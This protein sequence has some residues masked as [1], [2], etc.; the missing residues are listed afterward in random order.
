MS[1]PTERLLHA[2][3]DLCDES[4]QDARSRD[5]QLAGARLTRLL[6]E[7]ASSTQ[8]DA[9]LL[10]ASLMQCA[11]QG[12]IALEHSK[13][14]VP[15]YLRLQRIRLAAGAESRLRE[16]L[17]RPARGSTEHDRAWAAALGEYLPNLPAEMA[18][19]LR[20]KPLE[21]AE[22][23]PQQLAQRLA[24]A[25]THLHKGM[26]LREA[27]A[28]AF[29]GNSKVLDGRSAL[30]TAICTK[31]AALPVA[32][33]V[34]IPATWEG[35][36][37]IE[38]EASFIRACQ[39]AGASHS[40]AALLFCSGF[41]GAATR[42]RSVGGARLFV[43]SSTQIQDLHGFDRWLNTPQ[44]NA[45]PVWFFG[46]LDFSGMAILRELR[47]SFIQIKAWQPGYSVLL[48]RLFAGEAH[49]GAESNK[50]GQRD[51]ISTGCEYS[52][53]VLLPAL[54]RTQQFVDQEAFLWN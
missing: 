45:M 10:H 49:F 20:R 27:S 12:L 26:S 3:L 53:T 29:W 35:V 48:E 6:P 30:I 50:Q 54:R 23:S 16:Q 28:R 41:R 39:H 33:Q 7:L 18:E 38:N 31:H 14:K 9:E 8:D 44:E 52:D 11:G 32:L 13:S 37:L 25:A 19:A 42:L 4:S 43:S 17:R 47:Q 5:V 46:D 51:P 34:H 36:L 2:L 22:R 24:E 21:L 40:R 1:T 15:E